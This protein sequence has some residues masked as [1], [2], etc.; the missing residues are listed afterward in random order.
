MTY[1]ITI[2]NDTNLIEGA[3]KGGFKGK[4]IFGKDLET[5]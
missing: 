4:V 3:G 2:E 5:I 1:V